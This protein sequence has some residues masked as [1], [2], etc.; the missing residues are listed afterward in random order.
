[1]FVQLMVIVN[2][3]KKIY[4]HKITFYNIIYIFKRRNPY[5]EIPSLPSLISSFCVL[6]QELHFNGL[7]APGFNPLL[8]PRCRSHQRRSHLPHLRRRIPRHNRSLPHPRLH[9]DLYRCQIPLS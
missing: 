7:P 2:I 6:R 5:Y 9:P 4:I 3:I 8:L 1:M